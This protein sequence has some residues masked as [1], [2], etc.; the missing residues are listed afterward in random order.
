MTG[1]PGDCLMRSVCTLY[2]RMEKETF[3]KYRIALYKSAFDMKIRCRKR[4]FWTEFN[5]AYVSA[6]VQ[7]IW[8]AKKQLSINIWYVFRDP[9]GARFS[10]LH[11]PSTFFLFVHFV[12][13]LDQCIRYIPPTKCT[14]LLYTYLRTYSLTLWS[15]LLL[16]KLSGLQLVK[17]LPTFYGTRRFIVLILQSNQ[18]SLC[19]W[20]LPYRKLRVTFKVSPASLQTLL[21][22]PGG[23]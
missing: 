1:C 15:R 14:G 11:V 16:V 6:T 12:H 3:P 13:F 20:W 2:R 17:K 18:K 10:L 7:S 4:K 22:G 19:T 8:Q 23:H 9:F 5:D 21:T